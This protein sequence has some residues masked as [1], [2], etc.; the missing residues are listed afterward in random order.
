MGELQMQ[1][2]GKSI[3]VS[4]GTDGIGRVTAETLARMGAAVTIIGRNSE[5][6]ARVA[7]EIRRSSGNKQVDGIAADLSE[8]R[9]VRRAAEEY[10]A[11]HDRLDVLVNNAGAMYMQRQE[12]ADGIEMTVALNHMNYF[13]L[14]QALLDLLKKSAPARIVNVSSMAHMG[15]SLDPD[16]L[17]GKRSYSGWRQY[18]NSKLMNLYFTYSLAR[19]LEGSGV[20][21]NA[22]HPGFVATNF[23]RS[24]GGLFKPLFRL[25]QLGAIS[26]E[27]GAATSIYLASSAEV[28]GIN[29]Q[30]FS[31]K[32]AVPSSKPSYDEGMAERLWQISEG[33][34][35]AAEQVN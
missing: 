28:E 4:G 16:N 5:K 32:K 6:T 18:S 24:N 30:Y 14:T 7:E 35:L 13:L 17:E 26:P 27:E 9:Q 22:L 12:S 1:L 25:F 20:T 8:Q 23:G 10:R 15:A 34:V 29:G 11:R 3:L 2:T 21:V 33:W 19:R 31:N